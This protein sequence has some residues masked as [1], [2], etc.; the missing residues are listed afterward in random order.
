MIVVIRMQRRMTA[1]VLVM[2]KMVV[3]CFFLGSYA[4]FPSLPYPSLSRDAR[5]L[6]TMC[7]EM[8]I[9]SNWKLMFRRLGVTAM[10]AGHHCRH[11]LF[12][13][14][15]H[16]FEGKKRLLSSPGCLRARRLV[17]RRKNVPGRVAWTSGRDRRPS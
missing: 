6:C 8:H 17:G 9:L 4:S 14:V 10:T 1:A 16:T 3:G 7:T 11:L 12:L 5:A 2:L 13:N 15:Q